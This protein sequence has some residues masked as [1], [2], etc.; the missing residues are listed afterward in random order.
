MA[1]L[2]LMFDYLCNFGRWFQN[3]LATR[4][5]L[6]ACLA[7]P[8][9]AIAISLVVHSQTAPPSIPPVALADD[10]LYATGA[11]E[12]PTMALALSVE[13]P[14]VGAQYFKG[15]TN[16]IDDSYEN[17]KEY[18][19]Y[20]DAESCY[21]Y[22]DNPA[23]TPSTGQ[24]KADYKRFDRTGPA[25]NRTCAD[26]FSGNFLNWASSS[27]IDMLR[28]SL[29]GGDR[30]ID[31]EDLTILQ[32]AVLPSAPCLWNSISFPAKQL[33]R[34]GGGAGNYWGAVPLRMRTDAG[35]NDIWVANELNQIF[36][37]TRRSG[38]CGI[39][40][41]YRLASGVQSTVGPIVSMTQNLPADAS[42]VCA[43]DG[44]T[45]AF[46]GIK[47]VWYGAGTHWAVAP[48]SGGIT[49]S[50]NRV[51]GDPIFGVEKS[52]YTR[53]YSGQWKPTMSTIGP[54]T[55]VTQPLPTEAVECASEGGTCTV[56]G[57]KEIW[58]GADAGWIVAPI[59][60]AISCSTEALGN[61]A[62][63]GAKKCYA[64]NYSGSWSPAPLNS[65][66]FF[67]SRVKVCDQ[68]ASGELL[69]VRDYGLDHGFCTRYPNNQ[70]KPT[71]A[72]QR[73]SNSFR[74][75][76]FGYALDQ[77]QS[78]G[79]NAQ[80]EP[81]RYGGVLRAPMK[82]VGSKTYGANGQENTPA[83]GNPG[84]EWDPQTGIFKA[85]PDGDTTQTPAI[86][87]V[88]NYLNKFGRTGIPGRYKSW[89]P[90]GELYYE[91]LRY[92]QGLPPSDDAVKG[93][94]PEMYDG[95]P[96]FKNWTGLDPFADGSATGNYSCV[97]S[98]IVA[99]G[100]IE[101]HDSSNYARF[102]S[103][104]PAKNHP[105]FKAWRDTAAA[106]EAGLVV[107]YIDGQGE[108]RKTGNP[109]PPNPYAFGNQFDIVGT[110][111]WAHTN[112]IRG[113]EWTDQKDK[114]RPGLRVKSFFFDV[115]AY[116]KQNDDATR[117]YRNQFF[118]AAKYGGFESMLSS[119]GEEIQP[120]NTWG[121]PF[122]DTK[123]NP[124]N[125]V[126]QDPER[127][128]EASAYARQSDARSVLTA[129]D[130]IFKKAGER[131]RSIAGAAAQSSTLTDAGN[132]IYQAEF[133]SQDWS[134]D[135]AA[136]AVSTNTDKVV[137]V[138]KTP[139]WR[140]SNRLKALASI[141]AR[142]IVIGNS[143]ATS[144]QTAS[145]FTWN[146]ISDD[147][148]QSLDKDPYSVTPSVSD[149]HAKERL[150]FIRGDHSKEVSL[151]RD[152]DGQRL[153][154]I[155]NSGVVYSGAPSG[156]IQSTT[157]PDFFKDNKD[158]K[159]A[160]FVG[161]NDGM[162]HAFDAS[163]GDE[164]FGYI[165]SWLGPKLS[166]LT[167]KKYLDNH[168]AYVDATPVVAEAQVGSAGTKADWKTVL[169]SGTG[170]G[171]RGVF[172]LDVTDP[173]QFSASKVMWEFTS[174]DD[175]DLGYVVGRPE[176]LKFRTS[177]PDATT[178]TYKWFAVVASGV[179]N[180]VRDNAGNFS[181]TGK[182]ALYLLDLAKAPGAAWMLD[183]NYYKIS[184]PVD[185][186]LSASKATGL[187]NFKVTLGAQQE[188]N[189][190]FM[191]D[192]HGNLWKLDF[193]DQGSTGWNISNLSAFADTSGNPFPLYIAKDGLGNVQPI[194]A[195]PFLIRGEG[196]ES[197][198]VAFGTG[199]F[200][201]G[202]DHSSTAVN[203]FYVVHDDGTKTV[204]STGTAA[205]SAI[206]GR[207]RLQAGV[208][209]SK[210]GRID[211]SAFVWGRPTSDTDATQRSGW[212]FDFPATGE[213]QA[214]ASLLRGDTLVF[215]SLIPNQGTNASSC[216]AVGSGREYRLDVNT[217][218]GTSS[219]ST[220]GLLGASMAMDVESATE[221]T[222]TDSTGRRT[223]TIKTQTLSQGSTGLATSAT[224][225][226]VQIAGRL[227]WRQIHNYQDLKNK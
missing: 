122:V 224:V 190:V 103:V 30:Y 197:I 17:G 106:F 81:G 149:G 174:A 59:T 172:A 48:A 181:T 73:Y 107:P 195:T 113:K 68:D 102:P 98:N 63:G 132:I 175:I 165:P 134:G 225:T 62:T 201:E 27:A 88:I 170:A 85:N 180:Y 82:W 1:T 57:T 137:Q 92:L 79:R 43:T 86:S 96:I 5:R 109:N 40:G 114:Q 11:R 39:S 7:F 151:F 32:R 71:G 35:T 12:K 198:Y 131:I 138:S 8:S 183:T 169:V 142:K 22:N 194:S 157:Y 193:R 45:C 133:S 204:D 91:T 70:H 207:G 206:T 36:F 226:T 90:V 145:N 216:S 9:V 47:E 156:T 153:G 14:T 80:G 116:G 101:T 154:D 18:I 150:A 83:N 202:T 61:P 196:R 24:S 192:M 199:K 89:D 166:A 51:F 67:Y 25:T 136:Y 15:P 38:T 213:R 69:D 50:A 162:L 77:T 177:A 219:T 189:K 37:G 146:S 212:Y 158:R 44:G 144:S 168:Q 52:C 214:F 110:A 104:D 178:P 78:Y 203:S 4:Q 95:F 155:V 31:R 223:R 21:A 75:A 111:Y 66:G 123:E 29:S 20:Y 167:S 10:P 208:F 65:D 125:N 126:W 55:T 49:C 221:S 210:T 94:T 84:A 2:I 182:P 164:L 6:L 220:V 16:P 60:G 222:I 54:V 120:Y 135:L 129:F 105:N 87:G 139:V 200:L 148:K 209:D 140:A 163:N 58:Y 28:L 99:I 186:S 215:S 176:I 97:K 23:E 33:Q 53:N 188:V 184:L 191:G 26:A 3:F 121:N 100:D 159:A 217:G 41:A 147:L 56:I 42:S 93:L 124:N 74:L 119:N 115:N 112:D 227:S 143:G 19:G 171:G 34:D 173:T 187:L 117:R 141:D 130:K 128:G 118:L 218:D 152:R 185:V 72:I 160:V 161:A 179:N 211:V 205:I 76:A 46:S 127:R 13:W 108:D 64:R